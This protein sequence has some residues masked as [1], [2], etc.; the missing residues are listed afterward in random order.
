MHFGVW[1]HWASGPFV[2]SPAAFRCDARII[3][4]VG[5]RAIL[6]AH[7]KYSAL[8]LFL[9]LFM[10]ALKPGGK[11]KFW[12]L[13]VHFHVKVIVRSPPCQSAV[14]GNF[15]PLTWHQSRHKN[16]I[17]IKSTWKFL[18][19]SNLNGEKFFLF[20][21]FGVMKIVQSGGQE[22]NLPLC[23]PQL[24]HMSWWILLCSCFWGHLIHDSGLYFDSGMQS[25]RSFYPTLRMVQALQT[26]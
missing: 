2:A 23:R 7:I 15:F 20:F 13:P 22:L 17:L 14:C 25:Y 8:P 24:L 5:Q 4:T 3:Q 9:A 11:P 12:A 26:F 18:L 10:T 19:I 1:G 6:T 16:G 21:V